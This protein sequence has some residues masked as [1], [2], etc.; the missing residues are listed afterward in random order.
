MGVEES[1]LADTSGG[2]DAAVQP[3]NDGVDGA[4]ADDKSSPSVSMQQQQRQHHPRP[5]VHHPDDSV[6]YVTVSD[7]VQHTEGLKGKFTMYRVAY[8]PPPPS[9][10]TDDSNDG[11]NAAVAVKALFPYA[12]SANRRYSDFSWLF[13]HLHKERPGAIVP[14]L[15]EKQQVSRFSES[16]IEERRYHLETFLRRVVSNPELKDAECLAMFLGG[17]DADFRKAK[18]DGSSFGSSGGGGSRSNSD[19]AVT[20][21]LSDEYA[22][23]MRDDT[24][25][26]SAENGN[27]LVD[28]GKERLSHKKA[29]I[30]K[31]IKEKKTTMQ[32][33]MVRS[34][35]DAVFDEAAHYISALEAGLKRVEAQASAMVKRDKDVSACFLEFGLGCDAL[36]HIDDEIDGGGSGG[37]DDA[38]SG[39]GKTFRMIG[40]AADAVSAMSSEHYERQLAGF[41][42]P[43]REHLKMVHAA[44]VALSKRNNRRITY[45]TC[46]NAVDSKKSNLHRYRITPGQE[47][48]AVGVETS[49]SRAE[50]AVIV[51]RA[52]YEEVG[53]R[54]LREVDRFRRENA[55]AMYATMAEFV[56]CQK[57]YHERMDKAWS[58]LLPRVEG[59]D[60]TEFGGGSFAGAAAAAR[61]AGGAGGALTTAGGGEGGAD[62]AAATA[63]VDNVPMP[64]YPPPPAPQEA[65]MAANGGVHDAAGIAMES[66]ILNGAIRYRDPLPEE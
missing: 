11:A 35:D 20:Q 39:V 32:G 52:N 65:A 54:V 43:L 18:R 22:D 49:L 31:W 40:T 4:P 30:K 25:A 46:L 57:E 38:S 58:E 12:T 2:V 60:E 36:A 37:G 63:R 41:A 14:P 45:S 5:R 64:S 53:A 1:P 29:G 59:V 7:P 48:K 47:G 34:P 61:R 27:T 28:K 21:T 15:P 6:A 17:G 51:A 9:A 16:F 10:A 62:S 56:R 24:Q 23:E 55:V 42:E 3:S 26:S 13:D 66:S 50:N 33:T 44:K 8:D 19:A